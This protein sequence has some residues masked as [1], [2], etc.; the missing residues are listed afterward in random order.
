MRRHV[1]LAAIVAAVVLV[2]TSG[3]ARPR[4]QR[5]TERVDRTVPLQSGGTLKL[6]N[7]SG[8]VTITGTDR[9]D[10][11][12]HAVRRASRDRLDRIHLD[13]DQTGDEVDIEANK[14]DHSWRD[15]GDNVVDTDFE[16]QVPRHTN[17]EV[18][19]FSSDV[20]VTDVTGTKQLRTFS[21]DVTVAGDDGPVKASTFSGDIEVGLAPGAS[22]GS[23]D[24][25]SFSG[26]LHSDLPLV[27]H[28]SRRRHFRAEGTPGGRDALSLTT[29]S[30]NVRITK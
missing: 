21:G 7:F 3:L 4:P 25:D 16:I 19:V 17:L 13:I 9:S 18:H 5:E 29:F 2:P 28:A 23:V 15:H 22:I 8:H 14:R 27:V 24:F 1:K 12:I 20:H 30:G 26:D 10:V 6:N 11:L